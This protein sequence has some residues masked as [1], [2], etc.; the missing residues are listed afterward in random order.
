MQ[1]PDPLELWDQDPFEPVVKDGNLVA[2]G[3]A[4]DKGQAFMHVKA[5][6]AYLKTDDLPVNLKMMIEGEEENGSKPTSPTGSVPTKTA[7][8]RTSCW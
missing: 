2:R 5:A 6:E 4:D 1:P 7:W 8:R 3:S